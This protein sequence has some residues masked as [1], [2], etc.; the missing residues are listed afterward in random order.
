MMWQ[1]LP[2]GLTKMKHW[3]K[4]RS[5][6]LKNNFHRVVKKSKWPNVAT[7]WRCNMGHVGSVRVRSSWIDAVP[8]LWPIATRV[9]QLGW[10]LE[11]TSKP[12]RTN[13]LGKDALADNNSFESAHK[14]AHQAK[15]FD[16]VSLGKQTEKGPQGLDTGR[17]I[18]SNK[19][20]QTTRKSQ[21]QVLVH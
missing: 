4:R 7:R 15:R 10:G 2:T 13:G 9:G 14:E 19:R 17:N 6:S 16:C 1:M 18:R 12:K 20:T 11:R 3:L 21:W 8:I 5:P